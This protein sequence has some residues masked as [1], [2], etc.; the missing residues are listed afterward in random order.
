MTQVDASQR[1]ARNADIV[2]LHAFRRSS[3]SF[4]DG[5]MDEAVSGESEDLMWLDAAP[6][7]SESW[8]VQD[9]Y[10]DNQ[11][12]KI[13]QELQEREKLLGD[14]YPF[15]LKQFSLHYRGLQS[16]ENRVYESL[17]LTSLATQRQGGTWLNVVDS[18]EKV[19]A[20]VVETYFQCSGSWWTGANS[21][22]KFREI[23][24][25]IHKHTGELEWNPDPNLANTVGNVRDAGVDFINYRNIVDSRIGGLFFY[26]QCACGDDWFAKTAHHSGQGRLRSLFRQPYAAP[27]RILTIPYLLASFREKLIKASSNISGFVFDRARLTKVLSRVVSNRD[28]K[29]EIENIYRLASNKCN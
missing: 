19:S 14:L 11:Q 10:L 2:E 13:T 16:V 29:R 21:T 3:A 22:H 28:I 20:R 17:L 18:F 15:R 27:V 4:D 9:G 1:T 23:I 26:G 8:S 25:G 12:A 24:D 7:E 6:A 5:L